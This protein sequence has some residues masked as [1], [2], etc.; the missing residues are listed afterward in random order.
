M[1]L[2]DLQ[3]KLADQLYTCTDN[4]ALPAAQTDFCCS[5]P[6]PTP[7]AAAD[8]A[9]RSSAPWLP[10]RALQALRQAGLQMR[11]RPRSRPQ[12]LPL[13]QS[14][15]TAAANGLHSPGLLLPDHRISG[16]LSATPSALGR[17]LRHQ[18][19]AVISPRATLSNRHHESWSSLSAGS[20]RCRTRQLASRQHALR[21]AR[22]RSRGT[23]QAGGRA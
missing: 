22:Q 9:A 15:S 17:N 11:S 6:A 18:S 20:L 19:R 12:V 14:L 8:A 16:Q 2:S 4:H 21:L 10:H 1:N 3:T 23:R 7:A 13:R 5:A